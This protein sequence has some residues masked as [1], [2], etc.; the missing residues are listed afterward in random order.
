MK[1]GKT[2]QEM[3][4][5]LD[6]Q[7][8]TK[9]DFIVDTPNLQM[10]IAQGRLG[11]DIIKPSDGMTEIERFG[12]SDLSH[13]QIGS[14]L[15][16]PAKYYDRMQSEIPELLTANINAWFRNDPAKRMIRTM[17]GRTRAF[18]S[19][20]YRR[21]DNY[22]IAQAVLPV[23]GEM[24]DA[25]VESSELTENR[26]YL[27]VVNPRLEVEVRKGDV[28][29]AGILISNSE[30]GLGAVNVQPLIYRL[31]CLNG[32]IV[33]DL[34][35]RR[36]HVGRAIESESYELFSD[37]TLRADDRAFMLKVQ[38]IVRTA[39]DEVKFNTVV[40]KMRDAAD[41]KI[42]GNIPSVVEL[43]SQDY[44]L[45]SSEQDNVLNYL[46]TGGD[47][48]LYGLANAV[49]RHSQDV[50]SYDRATELEALGWNI[51][52]MPKNIW[53]QINSEGG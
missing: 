26:M 21:I 32:M 13:R 16:I 7:N 30:V 35:Q 47:L 41:A 33:N 14:N 37:E 46:I 43:A 12:I 34:G 27:K 10:S 1:T 48:S 44:G 5:E 45:N 4:I 29:Q 6:R 53:S 42:S 17:D 18:L 52:N 24:K 15:G 49:T 20:R 36:Y 8:R 31:A 38:D 9:R 28:V 25:T 40:E 50:E 2:L 11:L 39:V 23:I 22:D 51:L 19:D 3:A